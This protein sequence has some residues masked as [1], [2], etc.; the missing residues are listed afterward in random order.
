MFC[1]S[2]CVL[3]LLCVLILAPYRSAFE[4]RDRDFGTGPHLLERPSDGVDFRLPALSLWAL[5]GIC[6]VCVKAQ[7][8]EE[9]DAE[10]NGRD[11]NKHLLT[12]L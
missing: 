3:N 2:C 9:Q 4:G 8:L 7:H 12:Q 6:D 10:K 11:K 1:P 5:F